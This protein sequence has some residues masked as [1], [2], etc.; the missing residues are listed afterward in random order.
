VF[1]FAGA[2]LVLVYSLLKG[3]LLLCATRFLL[4]LLE[5][6]VKRMIAGYSSH[7]FYISYFRYEVDALQ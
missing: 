5:A 1:L 4:I 3:K 7:K 6:Q 2:D